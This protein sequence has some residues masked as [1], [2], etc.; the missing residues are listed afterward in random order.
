MGVKF[1]VGLI[2]DEESAL[3]KMTDLI[4]QF[5]D[6]ELGFATSDPKEGLQKVESGLVDI[7]ITD[8]MIPGIGGLEISERLK[9]TGIPVI[10]YSAYDHFAV[11]GYQL[12][13]VYFI[14]KPAGYKEVLAGL[15]KA[16]NRL[17]SPI[18]EGVSNL[19]DSRIINSSGGV[20]G[21][22]IKVSE[23]DYLEQSGNYTKIFFGNT[24][25]MI[26][27]SLSGSIEKMRNPQIVRIHKSYAVNISKVRQIQFAELTLNNGV[28]IPIGRVYTDRIKEIFAKKML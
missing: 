19:Q 5:S 3:K 1:K 23:I 25:K 14:L 4:S 15:Q 21:E 10:L 13:A 20:T 27:S 22:L 16:K 17:V 9:G 12:D 8:V 6:F 18:L 2:D 26:V 7:L 28:I 24:Y 11:S